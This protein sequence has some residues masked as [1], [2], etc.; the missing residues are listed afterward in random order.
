[1][2]KNVNHVNEIK[3]EVLARVAAAFL[4]GDDISGEVERIP[5][6][7]RPKNSDH[8]RCCIYKDRAILRYRCM[9]AMGF[10][11]EDDD[12]DSTPLSHYV[13][14]AVARGRNDAPFVISAC[15]IACHSCVQA[16]YFVT[17][18]CQGCVA[19]P[20]VGACRFGAVH[21]VN[22]RSQIDVEKCRNCGKCMDMCPYCAIVR[23]KVPC[24]QSCPVNAIKKSEQG[25]AE[26]DFDKCISCGRCM[27]ACPFGT[28]LE[29]S[30][31]VD[32]LTRIRSGGHVSALIAPA[33]A[34]QFAASMP[35]LFSAL[36]ELGFSD[37]FE[38]A[39]GAD[40][41]SRHEADEFVER[42]EKG[43]RF[44]TTSCCP[45][46]IQSV[47]KLLPEVKPF[48][49]DTGTPMHYIAEIARQKRPDTVAVFIGPCVAK[50][51]EGRDDPAV[52]YVLTFEELGTMFAA[53]GID[54][55]RCEEAAI[56]DCASSD[57]RRYAI[58]GGVAAAVQAVVGPRIEVRP[59]Q[60]NGLSLK[61]LRQLKEYALKE[62]PGNLVEVMACE[63]GCVG[64]SGVLS[65]SAKATRAV[66]EFARK[67]NGTSV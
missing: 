35:Q 50:R 2:Q 47:R 10:L 64:G 31:V 6:I 33:F 19:H 25:R 15:D 59:V 18:I 63:G 44:M 27:R 1:M 37:V 60:V 53:A 36:K 23:I 48:V 32:V 3:R 42:M 13:Q 38:V 46:Y 40:V 17:N 56:P 9:A 29:R 4:R 45:G 52:D 28:I 66:E 43:E 7:M 21:I 5:Y 24:E 41:T 62:C 39:A 8:T 51:I 16:R 57:G 22:G 20:C 65:E 26:I 54:P 11:P 67:G 49:S 61:G 12:D 55:A 58:S 14:K 30:S 34:G